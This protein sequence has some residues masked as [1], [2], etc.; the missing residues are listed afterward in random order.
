MLINL[1]HIVASASFTF[2]SFIMT[3]FIF[4]ATALVFYF[5]IR[6]LMEAGVDWQSRLTVFNAEWFGSLFGAQPF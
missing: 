2:V 5:T 6:L 3:F 1:Y 4:A